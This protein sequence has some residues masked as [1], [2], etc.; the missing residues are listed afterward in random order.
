MT[1]D[2]MRLRPRHTAAGAVHT[3]ENACD[4]RQLE[5]DCSGSSELV[6]SID[7]PREPGT[8]GI[9]ED[10]QMYLIRWAMRTRCWDLDP[11]HYRQL[12]SSTPHYPSHH[13]PPTPHLN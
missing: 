2:Q 6:I 1:T 3:Q 7:I 13:A 9:W 8:T 4:P 10:I 5:V 12:H 11:T